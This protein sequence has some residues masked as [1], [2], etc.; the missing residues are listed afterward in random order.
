MQY[1]D[2]SRAVQHAAM[3]ALEAAM[4]P[5]QQQR[6]Q[7]QSQAAHA[8]PKASSARLPP[9]GGVTRCSDNP[10]DLGS[11]TGGTDVPADCGNGSPFQVGC[12]L[13]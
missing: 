8:H 1:I 7:L 12:S 10:M 11:S 9:S 4:R 13:V 2:A 3:A 5:L 6:L